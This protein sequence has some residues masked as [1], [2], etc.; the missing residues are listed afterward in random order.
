LLLKIFLSIDEWKDGSFNCRKD[1]LEGIKGVSV[2]KQFLHALTTF[3]AKH[4]KKWL[5]FSDKVFHES[6]QKT[7][8]R[9]PW[10]DNG[11]DS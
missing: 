6:M 1:L 8:I 10:T 3:K 9:K 7:G 11:K 4:R 5:L 2:Q